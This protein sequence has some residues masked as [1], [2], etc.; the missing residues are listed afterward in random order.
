MKKYDVITIGGSASGLV[1][2]MTGKANNKDKSFLLIRKEKDAMVPCGIPYIFGTLDSS[3]KNIIPL[4]GL[5]KS[6]VEF[7]QD[8][9]VKINRENKTIITKN[10]EEFGYDKLIVATG[11]TPYKPEWLKG[12]N[13]KNVFTIP[14]DKIYL[15]DIKEKFDNMKK[16][17]TIGAGFIGVEVSEQ[18]SIAGK[19]VTLIEVLPNILGKAFDKAIADNAQEELEK[20]GVKVKTGV[21]VVEITGVDKVDGILLDTGEKIEADAVIL[22]MGYRPNASLAKDANLSLNKLGAIEVDSYMRTDDE[23]IFAI[24]DCAAKVDFI[25][26]KPT[27]IM[28]AST[29]TSEARIAGM[30]LYNLSLVRTFSG[31]IAIFSTKIGDKAF[32]AA[33][34]TEEEAIKNGFDIEIGYFEG[35]D[36]HP[37]TLPNTKKQIVKLIAA[38]ESDIIIGGEVVGGDSIGELIN[39]I[40]REIQNRTRITEIYTSQIGTHPLLTAAPTAYPLVKAAEKIVLN[41]TLK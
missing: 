36:K 32:A 25:T 15:D 23:N 19:E 21:K 13:L 37:G 12:N 18:L 38:R 29:A 31:T 41:K 24:G 14:K 4:G 10:G 20:E 7:L 40:G 3:D 5:E 17:I 8:E 34:V 33:G 27:P 39:V 11:S 22:S 26:R 16:I 2:S 28:L 30:N 1:A 35:I 6:G 9:V